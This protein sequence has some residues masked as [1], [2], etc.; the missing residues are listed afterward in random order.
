MATYTFKCL[1]CGEKTEHSIPMKDASFSKQLHCHSC[2]A[3]TLQ[4]QVIKVPPVHFKGKGW[5]GKG[6]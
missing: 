5:P 4:I 2:E 1:C 3:K 6:T